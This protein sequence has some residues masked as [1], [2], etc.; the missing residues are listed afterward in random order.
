MNATP[1][2][3]TRPDAESTQRRC[4]M[5]SSVESA[6]PSRSSSSHMSGHATSRRARSYATR[7]SEMCPQSTLQISGGQARKLATKALLD[8]CSEISLVSIRL[9]NKLDIIPDRSEVTISGRS[10]IRASIFKGSAVFASSHN[11]EPVM[12]EA[13]CLRHLGITTPVMPID[14]RARAAWQNLE[15]ADR[16]FSLPGEIELLIGA[17]ALLEILKPGLIRRA[18]LVAQRTAVGWTIF[19]RFP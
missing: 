6:V 18:D 19:G 9:T 4:H 12:F 16:R 10:C 7:A 15:L 3:V 5:I 17:N 2:D 1:S 8:S 13:H 11:P 14:E